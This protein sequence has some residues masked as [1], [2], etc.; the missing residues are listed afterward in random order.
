MPRNTA[1]EFGLPPFRGAV[2]QIILASVV[3]YVFIL[4]LLSFAPRVGAAVLDIGTLDP[5]YVREGAIWQFI[6]YPF[7]AT[8]PWK[9]VVSLSGIYFLGGTVEDRI[10]YG[11]FW[12]LFLGSSVLS[13]VAGFVLSL[14]GVVA[15]GPAFG[16]GAAANAV[17]MVF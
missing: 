11:R 4:L 15:Q 10:G 2:R 9:F 3:V 12:A 5:R 14:T 13:G 1:S 8:D 17:L 7:M 6:T 16:V